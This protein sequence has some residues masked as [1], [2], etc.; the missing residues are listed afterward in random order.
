M[1]GEDGSVFTNKDISKLHRSR[2]SDEELER[3]WNSRQP[4]T[5]E[6]EKAVIDLMVRRLCKKNPAVSAE[7]SYPEN[8]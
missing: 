2:W 8:Q 6:Q 1:G 5:P 4:L 3:L 7:C